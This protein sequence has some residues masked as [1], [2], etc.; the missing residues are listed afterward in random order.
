MKTQIYFLPKDWTFKRALRV[1]IKFA[2]IYALLNLIWVLVLGTKSEVVVNLKLTEEITKTIVLFWNSFFNIFFNFAGIIIFGIS[3]FWI[4]KYLNSQVEIGRL[5]LFSGLVIG[6]LSGVVTSLSLDLSLGSVIVI[7]FGFFLLTL[8]IFG[9]FSG[10]VVALITGLITGLVAGWL[11]F[12]LFSGLVVSLAAVL[13]AGLFI[14]LVRLSMP[15]FSKK[16]WKKFWISIWSGIVWFWRF[17][18]R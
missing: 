17:L 10:F 14:V 12:G 6:S 2:L 8:V 5:E 11:S 7:G 1:S 3:L 4:L 13:I 15:L 9:L 16:F 18:V